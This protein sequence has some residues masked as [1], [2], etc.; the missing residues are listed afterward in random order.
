ME[1]A[2][3]TGNCF[4]FLLSMARYQILA[5]FVK[6][7]VNNVIYRCFSM[8]FSLLEYAF[9]QFFLKLAIFSRVKF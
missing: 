6:L 7:V 5:I 2:L 4:A 3:L 9:L 1:C 8:N